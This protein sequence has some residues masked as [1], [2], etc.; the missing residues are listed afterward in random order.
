[1]TLR[2]QKLRECT[3]AMAPRISLPR[4]PKRRG[5]YS[6]STHPSK[7]AGDISSVFPSLSGVDSPPLPPRFADLKRRLIQGHEDRVRDSWHRLL[8]DLRKEVDLIEALGSKVIPELEF[9]DMHDMAK[10]TEFRDGLRKRGVGLIRGVVSEREALGWKELVKRYVQTNPSTKGFPAENP[11]V[12]EL[13]WSP[14]QVLARAHPNLLRTQAFLM[15]HWHSANKAARISTSHPVAYADRLRIRQPGD[16]G[17]AL[18]PH[19]DGG[20]CERW[21]ENGYGKGGVY[22][23]IFRGNWEAYDPWESSCRLPVVSDLYNGPGGCSMFRM[24]QGWLSMSTTNPREGTLM[25]NPLLGKATA[26]FLLRPFFRPGR[27]PP[28]AVGSGFLDS[29][30]WSLEDETTS[31]LQGAVPSNCQELNAAFHPHLGLQNTMIHVP[32]VR[33]GDYVAWHCD[34]IHAV[35]KTHAGKDDSSVMYIPACPLTEANAEYLVRQR[36][37]FFEGT[38]GPDF[39]SGLGESQ[40]LGRLTPDFVMQNIDVEA[41]RA[42]GLTGYDVSQE[43]LLEGE[44]QT[45]ERANE[46]LGFDI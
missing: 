28:E 11:A 14:S 7:A 37:A 17:F 25:V 46:I 31:V 9:R 8:A 29:N 45:L 30:N 5:T 39:P 16:V 36:E 12:Y 18:G 26:Y 6:T 40:H 19:I 41:Q 34:T 3:R 1:M 33:P 43:G 2:V 38:P 42:L 23:E 44:R 10:R 20:S 15:S 35:D 21:E 4:S 24:F 27:V 32:Q 22:N 13:Y